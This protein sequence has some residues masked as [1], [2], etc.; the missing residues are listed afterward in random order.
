[1]ITATEQVFDEAYTEY[2]WHEGYAKRAQLLAPL[3]QPIVIVGCGFGFLVAEFSKL[4]KNAWGVDT[5][6]YC[7]AN[8]VTERFTQHDILRGP[9]RLL[10]LLQ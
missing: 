1:M 6:D 3:P 7:W 5:S 2:R 4:G 8:R 9:A 10:P